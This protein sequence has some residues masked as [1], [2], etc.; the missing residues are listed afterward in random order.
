M[1]KILF[2]GLP[3]HSYI[4]AI[5]HEMELMG[6]EVTFYP[7]ELRKT[8]QKVVRTLS[9]RAYHK[10]LDNFHS[11]IIEKNSIANMIISYSYKYIHFP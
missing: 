10:E 2:I 8:W 7:V 4:G 3:Y 1:K 5:S 6:Y 9:N 11:R